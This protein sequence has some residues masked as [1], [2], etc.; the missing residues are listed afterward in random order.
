MDL[1]TVSGRRRPPDPAQEGL[2]SRKR[3]APSQAEGATLRLSLG[4]VGKAAFSLPLQS[5]PHPGHPVRLT[6]K[7]FITPAGQHGH[8]PGHRLDAPCFA[9]ACQPWAAHSQGHAAC[10]RREGVTQRPQETPSPQGPPARLAGPPGVPTRPGP[11]PAP[12]APSV[13]KS[14]Q[15]ADGTAARAAGAGPQLYCGGEKVRSAALCAADLDSYGP[16]KCQ[17]RTG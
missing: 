14:L 6:C 16:G 1:F 4:V 2:S 12:C 17:A 3:G 7:E 10:K 8:L 11:T 5:P 13:P 9:G 15:R